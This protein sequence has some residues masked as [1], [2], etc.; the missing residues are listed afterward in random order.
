MDLRCASAVI[1]EPE[2]YDARTAGS[3]RGEIGSDAD[4]FSF[5]SIG[6]LV[7]DLSIVHVAT[8]VSSR[9]TIHTL[10]TGAVPWY[11]ILYHALASSAAVTCGF[12]P[13]V[14]T[15]KGQ[16]SINIKGFGQ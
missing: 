9:V 5:F 10:P 6:P 2:T 8:L 4:G 13:G 16:R 3:A 1:G 11:R 7:L 15:F 14:L 12:T